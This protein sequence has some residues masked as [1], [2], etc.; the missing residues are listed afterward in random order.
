MSAFAI[1][2][3][4]FFNLCSLVSHFHVT[5]YWPSFHC[6]KLGKCRS[7]TENLLMHT[8]TH[9]DCISKAV[10][11]TTP[12]NN[13]GL[14]VLKHTPVNTAICNVPLAVIRPLHPRRGHLLQHLLLPEAALLPGPLAQRCR[15]CA[16]G[17]QCS[18]RRWRL[19]AA[20]HC[21]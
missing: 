11:S 1:W 13:T 3:N 15:G 18:S 8:S 2:S 20:I 17:C 7:S 4:G 14:F 10:V 12:W 5:I 19:H 6:M 9:A 16:A 21:H